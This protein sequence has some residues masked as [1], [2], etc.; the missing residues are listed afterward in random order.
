VIK[1]WVENTKEK[2]IEKYEKMPY[3]QHYLQFEKGIKIKS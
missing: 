1:D 3:F 2:K